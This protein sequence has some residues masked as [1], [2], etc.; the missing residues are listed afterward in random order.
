MDFNLYGLSRQV[1][2]FRTVLAMILDEDEDLQHYST[3]KFEQIASKLYALTHQR[4]LLT[5]EGR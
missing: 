1:T 3:S 2:D 5:P 4:F